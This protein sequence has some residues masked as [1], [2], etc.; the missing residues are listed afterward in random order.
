MDG[1]E[2]VRARR[3]P[4]EILQ[5]DCSWAEVAERF[6]ADDQ[7][8]DEGRIGPWVTGSPCVS[9]FTTTDEF[10]YGYDR[11]SNVLYKN[12]LLSSGN[13]ELYHTNGASAGYDLL[14][15]LTDFRRG[16]LSDVNSDGVYD[17]VS[18]AS[19]TQSFSLDQL[20]NWNSLTTNGTA[21]SRT[22][23]SKNEVTAVGGNSLTF[24]NNGNTTQ[25][26]TG[27]KYVYDAWNRLVA[28]K[29]SGG[30]TL[31]TYKYD[32]LGRKIVEN[33]GAATDLYYGGTDDWQVLEEKQGS[34]TKAQNVWSQTYIDDV[35]LRDRD[36]DN[37]SGTGN[38]GKSGSGLEERLYVQH[39]ANHNVTALTDTSGTVQERFIY[40][41]YR[42]WSGTPCR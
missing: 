37:N 1:R 27:K 13:S 28:V 32:A 22:T 3:E 29:N 39:D 31:A 16:T 5:V 41:P 23:N 8:S 40:D 25:D 35:V 42:K 4:T 34:A 10:Q 26:E 33:P 6:S 36:A 21:Q 30:T 14:N 17:T 38:L 15:R 2:R 20:G 24:D 19:R 12:N 9:C 18:S 7:C 11:N